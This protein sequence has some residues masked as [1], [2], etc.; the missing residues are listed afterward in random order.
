MGHKSNHAYEILKEA[1]EILGSVPDLW[2]QT[3]EDMKCVDLELSDIMH[4]L[5]LEDF[6][7]D[8]GYD[9]ACEIKQVRQ[10]RRMV[11]EDQNAFSYLK[12]FCEKNGTFAKRLEEV[13]SLMQKEIDARTKRIYTPKIRI[14]KMRTIYAENAVKEEETAEETLQEEILFIEA[15]TQEPLAVDF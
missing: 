12:D 2:K 15:E 8:K 7:K 4:E 9:L 14:D 3:C 10:R 13:V 11:K 5:E 1:A 6:D